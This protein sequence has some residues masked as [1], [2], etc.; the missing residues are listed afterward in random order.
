MDDRLGD[1]ASADL[2]VEDDRIAAIAPAG[3]IGQE[4]RDAEIVDGR[5]SIVIPGIVNTHLHTWQT[6]LR[7]VGSNWTLL[8]YFCRRG[9]ER[10]RGPSP[11]EAQVA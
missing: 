2:L 1:L 8:E 4:M 5:T 6:A 9:E 10:K 7:S 11:R 3:T